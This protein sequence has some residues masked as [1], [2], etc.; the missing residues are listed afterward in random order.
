MSF[1]QTFKQKTQ[2]ALARL[3]QHFM[4]PS[5]RSLVFFYG[6][7]FAILMVVL[8]DADSGYFSH[9]AFGGR[10]IYNLQTYSQIFI[11]FVFAFIGV[12]AFFDY[13]IRQE[14]LVRK[15]WESPVG[16]GLVVIARAI[17]ALGILL[18]F[19][20]MAK[21]DTITAANY[22]NPR[23]YAVATELKHQQFELWPEH[24][25]P[26]AQMALM[27]VETCI[28]PTSKSC[29]NYQAQ[30]LTYW[31]PGC[32]RE[33]GVGLGEFTIAYN[34]DCSVR[35]DALSG[36]KALHPKE[37]QGVTWDSYRSSPSVQLRTLVLKQR[38]D[39]QHI[40]RLVPD[41]KEAIKFTDLAWNA[42]EGRV[43]RD[44]QLCALVKGCNQNVWFGN[45]EK[46]CTASKKPLYGSRSACDISRQHVEQVYRV[47]QAKYVALMQ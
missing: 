13:K 8:F 10:L 21:A 20:Q 33:N 37:L 27:D 35:F 28:T 9:F 32:K 6:F 18:A 7:V 3:G 22:V 17:V 23:A 46:T 5:M 4:K 24:P 41:P 39:Y 38:D 12:K 47:R 15:A 34:R 31:S 16:A 19:S 30:L 40:T 29:F 36:L 14:D 45:V 25:A 26:A 44:R 43:V 2:G 1:L 11:G 42:G